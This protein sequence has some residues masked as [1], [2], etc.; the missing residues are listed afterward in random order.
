MLDMPSSN[1]NSNSWQVHREE[2]ENSKYELFN[3]FD[4]TNAVRLVSNS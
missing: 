3:L 1:S 4:T 2:E